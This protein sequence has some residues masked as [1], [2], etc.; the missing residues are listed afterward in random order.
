MSNQLVISFFVRIYVFLVY[1]Q[2]RLQT[3]KQDFFNLR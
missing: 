2:S 3:Q 1:E